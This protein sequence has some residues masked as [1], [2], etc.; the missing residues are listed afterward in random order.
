M[1]TLNTDIT[2]VEDG[3]DHSGAEEARERLVGVVCGTRGK[4]DDGHESAHFRVFFFFTNIHTHD[5]SGTREKKQPPG[6]QSTHTFPR[7]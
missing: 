6:E 2:A 5:G 3:K 7:H 4:K 1:A